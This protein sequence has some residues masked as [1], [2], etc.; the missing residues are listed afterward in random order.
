MFIDTHCHLTDKQFQKDIEKVLAFSEQL[1]VKFFVTSGFDLDSSI[2][3]VEFA[4]LHKNVFATIG[5]YPEH[6]CLADEKTFAKLEELAKNKKVVGIG[7]IGLQFTDKAPA[8]E[9]QIKVFER[10]IDLAFDLQKPIVIHC[11]EAMGICLET[12]EKKRDKLVYGG[13]MHCFSGSRESALRVLKL[14]LN[15]SVGGVSTFK[16]ATNLKEALS[17]VP[18]ERIV[19][20]TDCPYLAPHPYRGQRNSPAFLPTIAENLAKILGKDASEVEKV[21]SQ[22]ALKLF[23]LE[24]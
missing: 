24:G 15:I 13:T 21:T 20:E 16:N 22:N 23:G 6:A 11:R 8:K 9:V 5:I 14:G 7:E 3:A 18:L 1:G 17:N 19:L 10:Q 2:K 12:L 4:S